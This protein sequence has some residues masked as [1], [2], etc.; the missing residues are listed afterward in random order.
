[1]VARDSVHAS[2]RESGAAE[3]VATADD[4]RDF[5]TGIAHCGYIGRNALNDFRLDAVIQISHQRFAA[6]FQQYATVLNRIVTHRLS[7][8]LPQRP[9][10]SLIL[11]YSPDEVLTTINGLHQFLDLVVFLRVFDLLHDLVGEILDLLLNAFTDFIS[12]E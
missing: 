10:R 3:D 5:Y 12:S 7:F 8:W 9:R 2:A 6:E 4:Y 1:M 11:A